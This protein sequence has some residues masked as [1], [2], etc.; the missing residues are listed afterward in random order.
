[1]LGCEVVR[2]FIEGDLL[3]RCHLGIGTP[4]P[5]IGFLHLGKVQRGNHSVERVERGNISEQIQKTFV[6]Q[7]RGVILSW[8]M[9]P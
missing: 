6:V 5:D 3:G 2:L 7:T 8:I 4:H 9:N 1:M